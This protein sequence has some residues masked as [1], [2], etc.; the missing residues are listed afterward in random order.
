MR[1][2]LLHVFLMCCQTLSTPDVARNITDLNGRRSRREGRMKTQ[3]LPEA[4]NGENSKSAGLSSVYMYLN[5]H[6][7][8]LLSFL[9]P[10]STSKHQVFFHLAA[11]GHPPKQEDTYLWPARVLQA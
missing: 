5:L 6:D 4:D 3:E 9:F 2:Y 1:Y 11:R 10:P 8:S 7:F